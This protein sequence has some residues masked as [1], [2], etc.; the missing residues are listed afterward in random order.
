MT[1]NA[2]PNQNIHGRNEYRAA[3]EHVLRL[4]N[5]VRL[6][7]DG[8]FEHSKEFFSPER[9]LVETVDETLAAEFY[10]TDW[11][12]YRWPVEI[13]ER[14]AGDA[15]VLISELQGTIPATPSESDFSSMAKELARRRRT[16]TVQ[17]L[18]LTADARPD[19]TPWTGDLAVSAKHTGSYPLNPQLLH[20]ELLSGY[21]KT[22]QTVSDLWEHIST[23]AENL[24]DEVDY[25]IPPTLVREI[26]N[27]GFLEIYNRE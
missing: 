27:Q 9:W 3:A 25:I 11:V 14:I 19:F 1:S 16:V 24:R 22:L 5:G 7:R 17:G 12:G 15:G 6:N 4:Y 18:D 10:A 8:S 23:V 13:S 26:H 2:N 21:G 20:S